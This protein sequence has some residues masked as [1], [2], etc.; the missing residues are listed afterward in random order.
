MTLSQ[1]AVY[2]PLACHSQAR[3]AA[4]RSSI[5]PNRFG[6]YPYE[7]EIWLMGLELLEAKLGLAQ[8]PDDQ[9]AR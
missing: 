2:F 9:P 5:G 1:R 6:K 8:A 7:Y 3:A 4:I